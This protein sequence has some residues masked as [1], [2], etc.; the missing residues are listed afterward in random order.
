MSTQHIVVAGASLA[1]LRACEALRQEG[2]DGAITLVGAEAE[3]P[4]D[5]P[6]LSKKVL[7]GEWEPDRIRLRKPDDIAS[8]HLHLRL[9]VRADALDTA[10]RALT[11]ADGSTIGFDGLVIATGAEPR[12]LPG[13]PDSPAIVTL[14]TLADSLGLRDRL[15]EGHRLVVIG[16]GFIGLEVAAT[17]RQRGCHVTVL[18]GL[19][20]PLVRGL[21]AE[22]P[23]LIHAYRSFNAL[24]P[25]FREAGDARVAEAAA[26][27]GGGDGR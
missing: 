17:A 19:P 15:G 2:F 1:G 3:M 9:G 14:R 5:R 10:A 23:D 21:G 27:R 7:A 25:A 4:Y 18:E 12:R 16:A 24:S 22:T 13:Q 8:L 6:P 26:E 20:A 11:L